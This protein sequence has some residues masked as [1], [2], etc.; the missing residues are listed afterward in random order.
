MRWRVPDGGIKLSDVN[1]TQD[2]ARNLTEQ[3]VV[4]RLR[5]GIVFL[6]IGLLLAAAFEHFGV[7]PLRRTWLFVP[8]FLAGYAFFQAVFKTCGFS[9]LRGRRHTTEGLEIVADKELRA[10]ALHTGKKQLLFSL[11]GAAALTALFVLI[12]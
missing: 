11:L 1:Y 10:R 12:G 4:R 3:H 8:F 6:M 2:G 9:A 7:P 5:G